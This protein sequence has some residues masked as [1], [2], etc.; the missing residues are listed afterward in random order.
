MNEYLHAYFKCEVP[1]VTVSPRA[2][3]RLREML[4]SSSAAGKITLTGFQGQGETF[5]LY[6]FVPERTRRDYRNTEPS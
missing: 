5:S 3:A 1:G 2:G 6:G 4:R